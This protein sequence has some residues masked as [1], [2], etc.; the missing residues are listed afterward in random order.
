MLTLFNQMFGKVSHESSMYAVRI[1]S[2]TFMYTHGILLRS[3]SIFRH[4]LVTETRKCVKP[5][6][7]KV[8]M[9]Q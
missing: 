9:S 6:L 8:Y 1:G 4:A 5:L 7:P 2:S 3:T